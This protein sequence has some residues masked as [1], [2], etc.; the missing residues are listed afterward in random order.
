MQKEKPAFRWH[1]IVLILL[2]GIW[3]AFSLVGVA[4]ALHH[5]PEIMG[6]DLLDKYLFLSIP[7]LILASAYL[8]F[9]KSQYTIVPF[10]LLPPIYYFSALKL[11]PDELRLAH[12]QIDVHYFLSIPWPYRAGILFFFSC[13]IYYVYLRKNKLLV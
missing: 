1:M 2:L 4:I 6:F 5:A 13:C 10:I 7:A 3:G 11:Y 8:L 12:R 9:A